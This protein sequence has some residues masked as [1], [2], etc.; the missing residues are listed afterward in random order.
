[1]LKVGKRRNQFFSL[2]GQDTTSY[3]VVFEFD[4]SSAS[5]GRVFRLKTVNEPALYSAALSWNLSEKVKCRPIIYECVR[6]SYETLLS[7]VFLKYV[8]ESLGINVESSSFSWST[9][10][11]GGML[12]WRYKDAS[13]QTMAYASR[14]LA[15]A[16]P[17]P[18]VV[19]TCSTW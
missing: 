15:Y 6:I 13:Y 8:S 19:G 4:H 1:M 9:L 3:R 11:L 12:I 2:V 16:S 18:Y 5:D 14:T 7:D 10:L 17:I